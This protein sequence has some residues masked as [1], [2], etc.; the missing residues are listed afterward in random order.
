M[1]DWNLFNIVFVAVVG[2]LS[3]FA[4]VSTIVVAAKGKRKCNAF[5]VILRIVSTLA[6]VAAAAMVL[7]AVFT[8]LDGDPC[9][10]FDQPDK[11]G[12]PLVPVLVFFGKET[13]L[14]LAQVFILLSTEIG[15][16][17]AAALFLCSLMALMVDCLV[18]NKKSDKKQKPVAKTAEQ[19]KREKELE[20]IRKIGESAVQ[21]TSKVAE[22]ENNSSQDESSLPEQTSD[23]DWREDKPEDSKNAEFVGLTE[24]NND[25]FD[26]FDDVDRD[27]VDLNEKTNDVGDVADNGANEAAM[28]GSV[29]DQ[30]EQQIS[31]YDIANEAADDTDELSE[32]ENDAEPDESEDNGNAAYDNVYDD[33]SADADIGET[34]EPYVDEGSVGEDISAEDQSTRIND[35]LYAEADERSNVEDTVEDLFDESAESVVGDEGENAD[36]DRDLQDDALDDIEPDRGIYIPEIRTYVKPNEDP[37]PVLKPEPAVKK[38]AQKT[39]TDGAPAKKPAS[40]AGTAKAG[41]KAPTKRSAQPASKKSA[42]TANEPKKLPVTRRYVILDR[43]NAVNM[44]GE[45]L[46]ER[47][48]AEKE[49]LQSSINTIIIE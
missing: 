45:Y 13:V 4:L 27:E 11:L 18:A 43:R 14:P 29:D 49:K 41:G 1:L 22:T 40:K 35:E 37:E 33:E 32:I 24:N 48:K 17:L 15:F 38:A 30:V 8:M 19:I 42:D 21:K 9:I 5:D 2:A 25:D 12:D 23:E 47:N 39:E 7:C 44:F 10:R 46:R 31:D 3:L 6:F 28:Q 34:Q 20:R 36:R 16:V 26:T